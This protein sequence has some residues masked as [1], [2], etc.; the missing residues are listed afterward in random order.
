MMKFLGALMI[1]VACGGAGFAVVTA[2][3][4]QLRALQQLIRALDY[5]RNELQ[6][7]MTSLPEL[8]SNAS[9]VCTGCV[10]KVL[11]LLCLELEAQ[12]IPDAPACMY[13]A[14]EKQVHLP[15]KVRK[16]MMQLGDSLGR[17][18]LTGQIQGLAAVE[19]QAE[20]EL[21]QLRRNQDVRLRSYQTLGL[22]AGAALVVLFL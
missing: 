5:M 15:E 9:R 4:N 18:D 1:L 6:F 2:Y 20:F 8:C 22:C 13:A 21:E 7:R 17:F 16:C 3:R 11:A 14:L 12:I 10:R 19:K